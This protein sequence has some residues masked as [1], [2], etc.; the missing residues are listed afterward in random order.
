MENENISTFYYFIGRTNPPTPAHVHMIEE[1]IQLAKDAG[2]KAIILLGSGPSGGKPSLDNPIDFELK[3]RFFDSVFSSKYFNN[4]VIAEKEIRPV[5]Q[6]ITLILQQNPKK[7]ERVKIIHVAGDKDD[8]ASKLSFIHKGLGKYKG[9]RFPII[10]G[11]HAVP[12]IHDIRGNS[13]S[14]TNIRL[15][16]YQLYLDDK[17][18]DTDIASTSFCNMYGELYG[19]LCPEIFKKLIQASK[20]DDML[21]CWVIIFKTNSIIIKWQVLQEKDLELDLE[22]QLLPKESLKKQVG[23]QEGIGIDE[24][25][26]GEEAKEKQKIDSKRFF[27]IS[28]LQPICKVRAVSYPLF[29]TLEE[30]FFNS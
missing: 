2:T 16:A 29:T 21:C 27:F 7:N 5:D 4:Y 6:L 22:L 24:E 18:K 9:F 3:K 11:T 26:E 12:P 23:K 8:D 17:D 19:G 20:K 10:T 1:T 28:I 13:M 25:F 30:M 14:A 15:K